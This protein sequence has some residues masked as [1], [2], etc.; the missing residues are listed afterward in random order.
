[1]HPLVKN[2]FSKFLPLWVILF[3]L[4][5]FWWISKNGEN[6]FES[7]DLWFQQLRLSCHF[8]TN[9]FELFW[10]IMLKDPVTRPIHH[11]TWFMSNLKPAFSVYATNINHLIN[12][13]FEFMKKYHFW[14]NIFENKNFDGKTFDTKNIL[15]N[16]L[17][18]YRSL[19]QKNSSKTRFERF[20]RIIRIRMILY[21]HVKS[22]KILKL[23]S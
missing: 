16:Y 17:N 1:M 9:W 12:E 4:G 19:G 23:F 10:F 20:K 6:G 21:V 7:D 13:N 5:E 3:E 18:S 11:V 14:S 8:L 22:S 15:S 2:L